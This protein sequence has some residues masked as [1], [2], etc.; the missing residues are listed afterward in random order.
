MR[1]IRDGWSRGWRAAAALALLAWAGTSACNELS[2]L[3][4]L[5]FVLEPTGGTGGSGGSGGTG[6][7]GAACVDPAEDCEPTGTECKLAVCLMGEC[8]VEPASAMT[9]LPDPTPGD[10]RALVCDGVGNE[11]AID[12]PGDPEDDENEC[13]VDSCLPDGSTSHEPVSPGTSCTMGVCDDEKAC[14]ECIGDGQCTFPDT[15][16]GEGTPGVCGC[17]AFCTTSWAEQIGNEGYQDVRGIAADSMGNVVLMGTNDG[18]L[19]VAGLLL[20]Q[21][22]ADVFVAKLDGSGIPSWVRGLG[23]SGSEAGDGVAVDASDSVIVSGWFDGSFDLPMPASPLMSTGGV[24]AFVVKLDKDGNLAWSKSFGGAA[25]SEQRA[26]GVAADGAGNVLLTGTFKGDVTFGGSTLTSA[27]EQDLFV[28]KLDSAGNHVWSKA[29]GGPAGEVGLRIATSTTGDVVVAG[30]LSGDFSIEGTPLQSGAGVGV[31]VAKFSQDGSLLW[32]RSFGSDNEMLPDGFVVDPDGAVIL[33]GKFDGTVTFGAPGDELVSDGW[34]VYVAKLDAGGN[35]QWSRAFG[36]A[37]LQFAQSVALDGSGGVL[38]SGVFENEIV[39][40]ADAKLTSDGPSN[41]FLARLDAGTGAHLAR[42]R[43]GDSNSPLQPGGWTCV[44]GNAFL[45]A[46]LQGSVDF[47]TGLL[48]NAGDHD[49]FLA[50]FSP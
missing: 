14:V 6:A 1:G 46:S 19:S 12:D 26:Y 21:S 35:H 27:G 9:A 8:S 18:A 42:R 29:F 3:N 30:I 23:G 37:G 50:K 2:G 41:L 24:D 33:S 34:D 31:F 13:T 47:G 10:C 28:A 5:E 38:L 15:C 16:G 17:S 48:M 40:D 36:G 44:A 25:T 32:A 39:F 4:E 45:A 20:P 43:F 49:I 22:Q 11:T 7:G